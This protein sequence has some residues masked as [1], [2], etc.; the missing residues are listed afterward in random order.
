MKQKLFSLSMLLALI[1]S[2]AY[3]W[4]G[5]D[6]AWWQENGY[7]SSQQEYY[8]TTI[9]ENASDWAL[10]IVPEAVVSDSRDASSSAYELNWENYDAV[11]NSIADLL[12]E[13]KE[14]L[15][16]EVYKNI[17][18]EHS[19]A[20]TLKKDVER[21]WRSAA[22][23]FGLVLRPSTTEDLHTGGALTGSYYYFVNRYE[24]LYKAYTAAVASKIL[25]LNKVLQDGQAA[26]D[27]AKARKGLADEIEKANLLKN[28]LVSQSVKKELTDAINEANDVYMDNDAT[29]EELTSAK[30]KLNQVVQ[31]SLG[32]DNKTRLEE[33]IAKIQDDENY[34]DL[35][36][37]DA[38]AIVDASIAKAQRM[39][40]TYESSESP[41][42]A[43]E[44]TA[45][46]EELDASL[47]QAR[48]FEA[49]TDLTNLVG[50][51]SQYS[52]MISSEVAAAQAAI[53]NVNSTPENLATCY[54]N[55]AIAASKAAAY[56]V[57]KKN[58]QEVLAEAKLSEEPTE[59][60][61]TAIEN[62]ET[63]VAK[64]FTTDADKLLIVL[65]GMVDAYNKLKTELNNDR[66]SHQAIEGPM[67]VKDWKSN[68]PDPNQVQYIK[69]VGKYSIADNGA[70]NEIVDLFL[71]DHEEADPANKFTWKAFSSDD[72]Y[73]VNSVTLSSTGV[74]DLNN[75]D[76]FGWS[77]QEKYND[78]VIP[79]SKIEPGDI[80]SVGASVSIASAVT[81][82]NTV[83]IPGYT[84]KNFDENGK[85]TGRY[86]TFKWSDNNKGGVYRVPALLSIYDE[87]GDTRTVE[88]VKTYISNPASDGTY[89]INT[90]LVLDGDKG[91]DNTETLF[92][93]NNGTAVLNGKWH[94]VQFIDKNQYLFH[95]AAQKAA[96]WY[97]NAED[98]RHYDTEALEEL[99]KAVETDGVDWLPQADR[100]KAAMEKVQ[101]S[102]NQVNMLLGDSLY[103]VIADGEYADVERTYT[104]KGAP[105]DKIEPLIIA[106]TNDGWAK[107]DSQYWEIVSNGNII[108]AD[109]TATIIVRFNPGTTYPAD[110]REYRAVLDVKVG[111]LSYQDEG[112]DSLQ[113]NLYGAN[114]KLSLKENTLLQ[115]HSLNLHRKDSITY[116]LYG[117][118]Y[119]YLYEK[120]PLKATFYDANN[121][122]LAT[123]EVKTTLVKNEFTA[124]AKDNDLDQTKFTVSYYP[125]DLGADV[126]KVVISD[127]VRTADD[128]V[129]MVSA[130]KS[131]VSF[132][133]ATATVVDVNDNVIPLSQKQNGTNAYFYPAD[134]ETYILP[135]TFS[136]YDGV[137]RQAVVRN[138]DGNIVITN[139]KI[140][141]DGLVEEHITYPV[142]IT[143]NNREYFDV[144]TEVEN[145]EG[146]G[147]MFIK[148][149]TND[150]DENI[151]KGQHDAQLQVIWQDQDTVRINFNQTQPYFSEI[152]DKV[153][154]NA[155]WEFTEAGDKIW[156]VDVK[157]V[158]N[159]YDFAINFGA[160]TNTDWFSID[161]SISYQTTPERGTRRYRLK[162]T[163]NP[164]EANTVY[165]DVLTLRIFDAKRHVVVATQTLQLKGAAVSSVKGGATGVT[166]VEAAKAKKNGKY[167]KDGKLIIV[168]D[169]LEYNAT[170]AQMK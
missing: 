99:R 111:N 69:L 147:T 2:I 22:F 144:S 109:S 36:N 129:L 32:K 21:D 135:I 59:K 105:G 90:D 40:E 76:L 57:A 37:A 110:Y 75:Y 72:N 138:E 39:L 119:A 87:T 132:D 166:N 38:K 125:E 30:T 47:L 102:I 25:A 139:E 60:L 11:L 63:A 145:L 7:T 1:A 4:T 150:L 100:I 15:P 130:A 95:Q 117:R 12:E 106:Q 127:T 84:I 167:F 131:S 104:V 56:D 146:T 156:Y 168:K 122:V 48:I 121:E 44:V 3:A 29:Y 159:Y 153:D 70:A 142:Q 157:D 43:D 77:Y 20:V 46:V 91:Y 19:S 151:N 148:V 9:R 71:V 10:G 163:Y 14:I 18:D 170:G 34:K 54:A 66:W 137:N 115:T 101:N 134:G 93:F 65:Q 81:N 120:S 96:D 169:G 13:N 88:D 85:Y 92:D 79:G 112:K 6:N 136:N 27:V 50:S 89:F 158:D 133:P 154:G 28:I 114:P 49:K 118:G 5:K 64:A 160:F 58:L 123:S 164:H 124:Y 53:D 51:T 55:L 165:E 33:A 8:Q 73:D 97:N 162:I 35:E 103:G 152:V 141:A 52:D 161:Q 42:T 140:A 80:I 149:K 45:M 41:V 107:D 24:D 116:D 31:A 68:D 113:Q 155:V 78:I 98:L 67:V 128:I 86:Y 62:G 108:G 126:V 143:I 17:S 83:S 61:A 74:S 94:H 16:A 23:R 26:V 82:V